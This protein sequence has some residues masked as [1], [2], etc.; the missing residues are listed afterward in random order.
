[1]EK[2]ASAVSKLGYTLLSAVKIINCPRQARLG[3]ANSNINILT[4]EHYRH[5]Y[6]Q[7]LNDS[8]M[9]K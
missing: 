3:D 1:M 6:L 5:N 7:K 2:Q 8:L 9:H 4:V